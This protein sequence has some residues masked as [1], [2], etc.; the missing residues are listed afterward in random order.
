V[1]DDIAAIVLAG[2]G[3]RRMGSDKSLL[4]WHGGTLLGRVAGILQRVADPVV[5]VTA[6]GR[7]PEPAA[8]IEVAFDRAPGHGPLEGI[9]AGLRAV[10]DRRP[11]AFVAAV[12]MPFLHPAFVEG[13]AALLGDADVALPEAGGHRHPTA[14][15]YRTGVLPVLERLL[16]AGSREPAELFSRVSVR[17][18]GPGEI[19]DPSSLENL[20]TPEDYRAALE[21][22]LPRVTAGGRPAAG[23]ILRDVW[24]RPG[25]VLLNGAVTMAV[26]TLPLVDGDVIDQAGA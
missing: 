12:D 9:A 2:G 16:A 7:A 20:N 21:R 22:P 25:A 10:G 13:L 6:P 26:P 11:A 15:V 4:D 14:A 8:G 17:V 18:V 24:D 19:D 1:T 3:S 23:A 5:V